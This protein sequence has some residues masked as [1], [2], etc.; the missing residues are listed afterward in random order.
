MRPDSRRNAGINLEE[1][2]RN[3]HLA[4]MVSAGKIK[5]YKKR[6]IFVFQN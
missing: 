2:H 6:M 4:K 1:H 3:P 5:S